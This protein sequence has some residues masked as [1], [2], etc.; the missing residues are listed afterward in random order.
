MGKPVKSWRS[1]EDFHTI[2]LHV[3]KRV[4]K[5]CNLANFANFDAAELE[6]YLG[7]IVGAVIL[8]AV[9]PPIWPIPCRLK[10]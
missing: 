1:I 3:V 9:R 8:E 5:L 7:A 10:S 4:E 2:Y 6:I